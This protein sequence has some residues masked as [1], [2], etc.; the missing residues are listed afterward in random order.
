MFDIEK[1]RNDFP[2][3]KNN[4]DLAYFDSSATSFKPQCVID[5]VNEY[6]C[7]YN[8]NI[9]RGD[10]NISQLAD[11]KYDECRK[12]VKEFINAGS[13][14]E[15]VFTNGATN[16]LN[17]IAYGYCLDNLKKGDV[18]LTT[19]EEHASN[20]LPL[21]R[22]AKQTGAIIEYIPLNSDAT[23]NIE[24]YVECFNKYNVKFVSLAHVSNVMGY[25]NPIKEIAKIAHKNGAV[26]SVDGAQSV[27]HIKVDVQDLDVDFLSFSSHKMLGPAGVG[28]LY[29][30]YSLLEKMNPEHLGGGA[31]AR[32]D[33]DGNVILKNPPE[34]FEAGTPN[35]EGIIGLNAAINYLNNIGMN[36]IEE[37]TEYL[38]DYFLNKLKELDNVIVYNEKARTGI[39]TFNLRNIFAQDA[40]SYFNLNN[41]AVRTGNHCA[42]ILFNV[43]GAT[44]TIRASM[45]LYNTKD[46]ID[47]FIEIIKD[48]TL[49][50]CV[51][52]IL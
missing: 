38:S 29:G 52:S 33:K 8:A 31:N 51:D 37:Y 43:I 40:A 25:I 14:K 5:A 47:R 21:F 10:Y 6:Y 20:I 35:I 36:N 3:I 41:I 15:I 39:I 28:V 2:M 18:I 13:H 24:N 44:E 48:T 50:K 11:E 19:E 4:P 34:V 9:H 22:V 27:P 12:T 1:I 45:Y 42:K 17:I 49:E 46:E 30:K 7:K 26:I 32:F 23:F 16:S